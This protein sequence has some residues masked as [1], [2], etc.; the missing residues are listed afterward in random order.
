MPAPLLSEWHT[1]TAHAET[2]AVLMVVMVSPSSNCT[3]RHEEIKCA[4]LGT[5]AY[6][7]YGSCRRLEENHNGVVAWKVFF[8]VAGV[9]RY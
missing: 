9:E 7:L 8:E 6:R 5:R 2:A 4:A 1:F 3:K